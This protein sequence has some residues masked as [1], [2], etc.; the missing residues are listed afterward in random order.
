MPDA[1]TPEFVRQEL[2]ARL[3]KLR[4]SRDLTVEDVAG[5]LLCSPSKVS[6]METG[7]RGASQ[8]DVRDLCDL[9]Q[10]ADP[11]ERET[12]MA[13]ARTGRQRRI[14]ETD[15]ER[16]VYPEFGDLVE[17]AD[18]ITLFVSSLLPALFQTEDYGR[19][20]FAGRFPDVPERG[21][22]LAVRDNA[23]RQGILT[24]RS[25]P[26]V[27]ALIDEAALHRC[28]GG[29][30][31]MAAQLDRLERIASLPNV[32]L[33]ILPFSAGA[34]VGVESSFVALEFRGTLVP[35]V[36]FSEGLAGR[37]RMKRNVDVERYIRAVE[38]LEYVALN[39]TDSVRLISDARAS[40]TL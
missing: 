15:D 27:L 13:L 6:R 18:R 21:I 16:L 10:V 30:A 8:R 32:E 11:A 9:Y 34:H 39:L 3:R 14:L 28:V 26:Q 17:T 5:Q 29:P 1:T 20:Q 38:S 12:L 7:Q 22:E 37:I 4:L 24:R 33:H 2:G 19:A 31:V 40:Y 35:N 25:P 36:V 23:A